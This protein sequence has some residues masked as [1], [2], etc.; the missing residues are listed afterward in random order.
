M[1]WPFRNEDTK[2]DRLLQAEQDRDRYKAALEFLANPGGE[3][4]MK[5]NASFTDKI[6]VGMVLMS[7]HRA[8]AAL[9]DISPANSDAVERAWA[10][11]MAKE[12]KDVWGK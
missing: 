8:R 6:V 4:V 11:R 9:L 7:I 3:I 1:T 2:H 10:E 5:E 12:G